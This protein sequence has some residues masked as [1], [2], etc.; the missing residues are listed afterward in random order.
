M[1]SI[2]LRILFKNLSVEKRISKVI[3]TLH[4]CWALPEDVIA[5]ILLDAANG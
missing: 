2:D 4:D 5:T 1:V 3:Y